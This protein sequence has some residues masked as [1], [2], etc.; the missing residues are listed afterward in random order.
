MSERNNAPVW[1]LSALRMLVGWHFL[2]EGIVKL[3]S[4]SW[5][6]GP[7]MMESTWLFSGLFRAAALNHCAPGCHRFS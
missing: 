6:A 5:S 2:Y 3:A 4:P 1:I 7:F